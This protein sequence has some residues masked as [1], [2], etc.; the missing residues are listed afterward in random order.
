MSTPFTWIPLGGIDVS[1]W[2]ASGG[3]V[4]AYRACRT[5]D[6]T[7]GPVS[8]L[9]FQVDVF[10]DV[11]HLQI[12]NP[13]HFPVYMVCPIEDLGGNPFPSASV[14]QPMLMLAGRLIQTS[15]AVPAATEGTA[16]QQTKAQAI[17]IVSTTS[18]QT[19]D[20]IDQTSVTDYGEQA[21]EVPT[22][23]WNQHIE[24]MQ[25]ITDD[26]VAQLAQPVPTVQPLDIVGDPRLQLTDRQL[27]DTHL[28]NG[29]SQD[30]YIVGLSMNIEA[31]PDVGAGGMSQTVQLRMVAPPGAWVLGDTDYSAGGVTHSSLSKLGSTTRLGHA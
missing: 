3:A 26:L 7:G 30:G 9:I 4:N 13:N 17:G 29:M 6:G 22:S 28:A 11:I 21:Y 20:T 27:I 18:A 2:N 16:T 15:T 25:S 10:A 31:G 1:T 14:G 5:P 12:T 24:S 19:A 23:S 8:N